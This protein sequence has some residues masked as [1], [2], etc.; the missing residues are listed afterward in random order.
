MTDPTPRPQR[1]I[2]AHYSDDTVRVYQ[3]YPPEIAEPALW[4]Q[5]FVPPFKTGRMTWIKPSFLWMMYRSGWATKQGQE[6]ILAIDIE[7]DGFDWF[8]QNG[9]LSHFD[10]S[11]HESYGEWVEQKEFSSIRIQWDPERNCDLERLEY[12]SIQVGLSGDAVEQYVVSW[13]S[14]I[15]DFTD[16]VKII[17]ESREELRHARVAEIAGEERPYPVSKHIARRI[18]MDSG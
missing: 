7:R 17:R 4:A 1:Q 13:V 10:P 2:R 8:L 12:R 6:R 11:V 3:A 18:G 16:K 5:R 15:T 14:C 9:C